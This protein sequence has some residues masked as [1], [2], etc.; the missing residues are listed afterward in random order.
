MALAKEHDKP[1][2]GQPVATADWTADI[3]SNSVLLTKVQHFTLHRYSYRA[4]LQPKCWHVRHE[5][6][7]VLNTSTAA[8][9]RPFRWEHGLAER[10]RCS[11]LGACKHLEP[12]DGPKSSPWSRGPAQAF[13]DLSRAQWS[14]LHLRQ[15]RHWPAWTPHVISIF[16]Q[17]RQVVM[18]MHGFCWV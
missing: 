17:Q 6:T 1:F 15:S 16:P 8:F 14:H 3:G 13:E 10:K 9:A 18:G 4:E 12:F 11:A 2:W 5:L 7:Q